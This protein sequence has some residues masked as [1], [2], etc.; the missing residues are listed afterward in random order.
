[1]S[2]SISILPRPI[3]ANR[4]TPTRSMFTAALPVRLVQRPASMHQLRAERQMMM[5]VEELDHPGVLAYCQRAT[6]S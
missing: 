5:A 6:R 4:T 2:I 3:S 1:M